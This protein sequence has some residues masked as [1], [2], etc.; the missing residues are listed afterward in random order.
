VDAQL[1]EPTDHASLETSQVPVQVLPVATQID[2][3][4]ADQ[5]PRTVEGHISPTLDLVHR[6]APALQL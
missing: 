4:V 6:Y 5:L 1:L 2:N 3:R